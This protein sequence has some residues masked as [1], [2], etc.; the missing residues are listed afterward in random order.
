MF[1]VIERVLQHASQGIHQTDL[2]QIFIN[3]EQLETPICV[4]VTASGK[5]SPE[6]ILQEIQKVLQSGKTLI[7]NQSFQIII[8]SVKLPRGIGRIYLTSVQEG[9]IIG[10]KRSLD[11]LWINMLQ[12]PVVV[13]QLSI[14]NL[15]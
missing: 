10:K 2:L 15:P 1:A 4:P 7:I 9:S 8:G 3:Y 14:P 5:M 6:Q 13:R 11:I 12:L